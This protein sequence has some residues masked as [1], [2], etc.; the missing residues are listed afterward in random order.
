[1]SLGCSGAGAAAALWVF[2]VD[3]DTNK[4]VVNTLSLWLLRRS[5]EVELV[6]DAS[7]RDVLVEGDAGT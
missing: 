7:A 4:A 1:M 6:V 2:E 3:P 5:L